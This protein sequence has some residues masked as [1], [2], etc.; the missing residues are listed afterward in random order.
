MY[1]LDIQFAVI[2]EPFFRFRIVDEVAL[3]RRYRAV[4]RDLD[5]VN[6]VHH[7]SCICLLI[8][9]LFSSDGEESIWQDFL[10]FTY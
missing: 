8:L 10:N 7:G 9:F 4:V 6:P 1:I 2:H 3:V 5:V